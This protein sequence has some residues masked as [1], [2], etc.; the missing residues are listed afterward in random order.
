[1]PLTDG[2]AVICASLN[3]PDYKKQGLTQ[4]KWGLQQSGQFNSAQA[5]IRVALSSAL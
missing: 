5:D 3:S 4:I 1:M 2:L